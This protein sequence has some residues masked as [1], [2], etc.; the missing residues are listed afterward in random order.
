MA[1]ISECGKLLTCSE[2]ESYVSTTGIHSDQS[3]TRHATNTLWSHR[4]AYVSRIS[5]MMLSNRIIQNKC[6]IPHHTKQPRPQC[7]SNSPPASP[8]LVLLQKKKKK[9]KK[10]LREE[11]FTLPASSFLPSFLPLNYTPLHRSSTRPNPIRSVGRRC[12]A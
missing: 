5:T 2:I 11:C 10:K 1:S 9:K 12:T 3:R 7:L 8:Y 4:K 6:I